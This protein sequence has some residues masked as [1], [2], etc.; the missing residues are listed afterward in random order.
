MKRNN[1]V[2]APLAEMKLSTTE[3]K[4]FTDGSLASGGHV[5]SLKKERNEQENQLVA[6]RENW[7]FF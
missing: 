7:T 4:H 1:F 3:R 6:A 2:G 5:I